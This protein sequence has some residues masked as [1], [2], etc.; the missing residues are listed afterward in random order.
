MRE[1]QNRVL[2][3]KIDVEKKEESCREFEDKVFMQ[4]FVFNTNI[5]L[6]HPQ[7]IFSYSCMASNCV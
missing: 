1:L 3:T 4:L 7:K 6:M 5:T 2:K